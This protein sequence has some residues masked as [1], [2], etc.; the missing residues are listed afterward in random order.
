MSFC[1]LKKKKKVLLLVM[2]AFWYK[3]NWPVR[4]LVSEVGTRFLAP[5]VL[6]TKMYVY[7]MRFLFLKTKKHSIALIF[8]FTQHEFGKAES[9]IFLRLVLSRKKKKNLPANKSTG[10]ML[11]QRNLRLFFL[12]LKYT[13]YTEYKLSFQVKSG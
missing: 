12:I 4:C 13:K 10:V 3:N 1:W 2:I 11:N 6:L 9:F 7:F 8:S 5:V